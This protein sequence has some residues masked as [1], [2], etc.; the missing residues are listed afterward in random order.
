MRSNE[1]MDTEMTLGSHVPRRAQPSRMRLISKLLPNLS[2]RSSRGG[3]VSQSVY[4]KDEDRSHTSAR[5]RHSS[6]KTLSFFSQ[7]VI[8]DAGVVKECTSSDCRVAAELLK[9]TLDRSVKPCDDFYSYVCPNFRAPESGVL[10]AVTAYMRNV[11]E[12]L[13]YTIDVPP[14]RQN[15]LQKAAG[16]YRACVGVLLS[17]TSEVR[18]VNAC[19][20]GY[21]AAA[22]R[23]SAGVGGLDTLPLQPLF[24][25]GEAL[26]RLRVDIFLHA[27]HP[28]KAQKDSSRTRCK[29]S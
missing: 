22:V 11:T 15:A 4:D 1:E 24:Y 7:I 27:N 23:C 14:S 18:A 12:A 21:A 9:T 19:R 25:E 29:T 26:E 28:R 8:A 5:S 10:W 17:N 16:M 13:L 2:R 20:A 3:S 6:W